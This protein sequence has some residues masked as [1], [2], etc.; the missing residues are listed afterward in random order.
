[1]DTTVQQ[2]IA[3]VVMTLNQERRFLARTRGG[4]QR[5]ANA[6]LWR[7]LKAETDIRAVTFA[8]V[9]AHARDAINRQAHRLARQGDAARWNRIAPTRRKPYGKRAAAAARRRVIAR[10]KQVRQST[11]G[12]TG[13]AARCKDVWPM[14]RVERPCFG[15]CA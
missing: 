5:C 15:F 4:G 2:V 13:G 7:R 6:D 8:W 10:P 3:A 12:L 9:K 14:Q 1:M 11:A